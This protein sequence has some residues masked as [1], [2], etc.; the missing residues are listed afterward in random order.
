[1]KFALFFSCLFLSDFISYWFQVY[2]AYLLDEPPYN[3][4][5]IVIRVILTLLRFPLI[6][7]AMTGL[8]E[9]YVFGAYISFFP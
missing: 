7:L 8:A 2:S 1:M 9:V 5:N 6:D 3:S 4:K